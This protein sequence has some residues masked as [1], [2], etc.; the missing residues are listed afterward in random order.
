MPFV[1]SG[2]RLLVSIDIA[3][4]GTEQ[5][6]TLSLLVFSL[7]EIVVRVARLS[8]RAGAGRTYNASPLLVVGALAAGGEHS[9]TNR[10]GGA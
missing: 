9:Q 7:R 3:F 10:F 4:R 1:L 2:L 6:D 5:P 8:G